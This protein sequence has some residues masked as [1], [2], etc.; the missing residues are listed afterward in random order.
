M[1]ADPIDLQGYFPFFLGTIANRWTTTSSRIYLDRFGI[2]IGEWRVLSSIRSLGT[3]SSQEVVVLISMDAGAVSRS[4]AKLEKDGFARPIKGKF[5][6]RTK[7]YQL[8]AKGKTL[9]SEIA[10]IALAREQLLLQNLSSDEQ[11]D[12]L[13]LMRKIMPKLGEL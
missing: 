10:A 11:A 12:L 7:P 4:M 3:A 8:T 2:G 6:G 1:S 5:A 13:R 9:H